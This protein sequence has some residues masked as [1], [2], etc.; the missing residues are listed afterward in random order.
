[1]QL[2]SGG[3]RKIGDNLFASLHRIILGNQAIIVTV[4]NMMENFNQIWSWEFFGKNLS[5]GYPLIYKDLCNLSRK[6]IDINEFHFVISIRSIRSIDKSNFLDLYKDN[7]I[8]MLNPNNNIRVIIL[9]TRDVYNYLSK[10]VKE[11][12]LISYIITGDYFDIIVGLRVLRKK[13]GIKYL[14]NDGGRIMSNSM[15][16]A[17]ILGEERIT[18]EPFDPLTLKYKIDDSCILGKRGVGIDKSEL[19]FSI[20]LDSLP[21]WE[22][23]ANVYLYPLNEKLK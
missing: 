19:D 2:L 12:A 8:A 14:L 13:Y 23:K 11:S 10:F 16:D 7:K 6:F 22:E 15:R 1:V 9:T 18:L 21:I 4:N 20:L 3:E 17:G 5:N